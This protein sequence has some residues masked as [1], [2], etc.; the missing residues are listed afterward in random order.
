MSQ[1]SKT[2]ESGTAIG[3]TVGSGK[4]AREPTQSVKRVISGAS[5]VFAGTMIWQASNFL[6]NAVGAHALGPAR[7]GTLAASLALLSFASPLLAAIQAVASRETTT[8]A[9]RGELAKIRPMLRHYGLRVTGGA[10]IIGAI[11][12]ATSGWLS[13]LFHLGS[14]W[15]VVIV[16]AV[17]PAYALGHLLAGLLQGAERFGRF[18]LESLVEGSTKAGFGILAMALLWR[19]AL[20]GMAAVALSCAAAVA[21][22]LAMTLPLLARNALSPA[23][24]GSAV[25]AGPRDP[26]SPSAG[27]ASGRPGVAR[28]SLAALAIYG[29]LAV[30]LSSDTLVAK[31]YLTN[32]EAGLYAGVSLTGKIAYLSA[33]SLFVVAFPLFSRHHDSGTSSRMWILGAG[34]LVGTMTGAIVLV[35]AV[36]PTWVVT[37]LLG[38]RYRAVEPY[39][40][41]MAAV[42]GLYALGY[43]VAIYLLARKC[44]SII[45]VLTAALAVQFTGLYLFHSAITMIMDVLAVAFA[46]L[47]LGGMLVAVRS[48]R[49]AG[50]ATAPAGQ[51][52]PRLPAVPGS[53]QEQIVAEVSKRVGSVPVLLAGSRALGTAH[54]GSDYDVSVVLP[55]RRIPQAVSSLAEA[56]RR[57]SADLGGDVSV[58][59]V[60]RFRMRHPGGS[61]FVG[62]LRAE[63]VTL[64]AP[65]GWSL[66]R[67]PLTGVTTF[68]ATSALLSAAQILIAAFDPAVMTGGLVPP[69]ARHALA[70]AALHVAQ[71]RLLRSGRYATDLKVA[72]S[73]LRSTP[74]SA[75]DAAPAAGLA[76]ALTAGLMAADAVAGFSFVR[77][78]ILTQLG[79]ITDTPFR[80]PVGRCLVRNL[81]YAALAQLRGRN[82]WRAVFRRGPVEAAL[83]RTQLALLR[84]LDPEAADGMDA[85]QLRLAATA[86]PSFLTASKPH[87]WEDLRDLVLAEWR[88]AHP[89]VGVMA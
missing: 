62:K 19:S 50:T 60:P 85:A 57:L 37:P 81:Q 6:F 24:A 26:G 52:S 40:P 32:H 31:H 23:A 14:P 47:C 79:D 43:L 39:M 86:L 5:L 70:K 66:C 33:S 88:D 35:Y 63:A 9:D 18:A 11:V 7:Y 42:F 51:P 45:A 74:P 56:A 4:P 12:I 68:A 27:L 41:W 87:T 15:L 10:L 38:G 78:C 75:N 59:P 20:S 72:L 17:I 30:M 49:K 16:G 28:L 44:W 84:A 25:A 34:A 13:S 64:A 73:E 83:A 67:Q 21:V 2:L 22:Y 46:V 54:A 80:M 77:K 65:P 69:R 3:A 82:R 58:N 89:L 29:L 55:L 1:P 53:W 48:G 61:L 36:E 8:L 76:D 71:V